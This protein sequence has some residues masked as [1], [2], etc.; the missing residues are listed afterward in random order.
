MARE[1]D[2]ITAEPLT[3]NKD[4]PP[5]LDEPDDNGGLRHNN[6]EK[7]K[8]AVDAESKR[9]LARAQAWGFYGWGFD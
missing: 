8:E 7:L 5:V 9:A 2:T 4:H 1:G 6:E 3:P